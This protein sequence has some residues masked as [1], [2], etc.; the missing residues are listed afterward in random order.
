ML[1]G[2][3]S[4]S[5]ELNSG[6]GKAPGEK[7]EE[8]YYQWAE[9][10]VQESRWAEARSALE[11]ALD[12]TGVSSDI[13]FLFAC[14]LVHEGRSRQAVLG[15][16][17]QAISTNRWVYHTEAEARFMAAEQLVTMRYY[18]A[19]LA[20]LAE[21]P[22][23]I[24]TAVLR[25][26]ALKKASV[27]SGADTGFDEN[28]TIRGVEFRKYLLE[29]MDRYP[30][31]P[32]PLRIFFDY[33]RGRIPD[34]EE[35]LY[36]SASDPGAADRNLMELALKRLPFL[37][38][39]DPELAWMAAPFIKNTDE[40]FRLLSAYR[41][42][43]LSRSAL[44]FKP[45]PSSIAV[46]L[47]FGAVS[48]TQAAEELFGHHENSNVSAID[49]DLIL[50]VFA[51]LRSEEDRNFFLQKLVSYSGIIPADD[52]EDGY[53]ES[54]AVYTDGMLREYYY[55]ADQDGIPDLFISFNNGDPQ[56]AQMILTLDQNTLKDSAALILW[57]RYP[58]VLRVEFDKAVYFP[59]PADF[60][61]SPVSFT[62]LSGNI[63]YA[64]LLYPVPEFANIDPGL[65]R[66][67]VFNSLQIQRPSAEFEDAV[68]WIDLDR[69]IPWRATEILDG[70]PVSITEY[71]QG[72]PVLQRVD[73]DF[74]SRMETIRY[75]RKMEYSENELLGYQKIVELSES[76]WNG[77]GLYEYA[78]EYLLDGSV[79]YSW[80]L[81]GNGVRNY[82]EIKIKNEND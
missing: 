41:T 22:E 36:N 29:T 59:R 50:S 49:R 82:S 23:N 46:A 44:N 65:L 69:G 43:S 68:E 16:L 6:A 52:D 5:Q 45:H 47:N 9:E 19:A 64:G 74:D 60:Q 63:N 2:L 76:D 7:P 13:S 42:G 56:W 25:L 15:A 78:E 54:R 33:A 38:E 62:E 77:D 75:F 72:R 39:T 37:L 66:M 34:D 14:V 3:F 24:E 67:L 4:Q 8:L 55:D 80:D 51:L 20:M 73:L 61:F 31:D 17:E 32:R 18:S 40:A 1:P 11:R 53:P 12:F 27:D 70:K 79:V 71:E 48:D 35:P 30:R 58:S 28:F 21:V 10:A 26:S 81:D 57:E